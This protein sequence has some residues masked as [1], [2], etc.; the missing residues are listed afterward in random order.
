MA[1]AFFFGPEAIQ[2]AFFRL[3]DVSGVIALNSGRAEPLAEPNQ[4]FSRLL[5]LRYEAGYRL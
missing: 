1:P 2:Q 5:N 3:Q 4:H